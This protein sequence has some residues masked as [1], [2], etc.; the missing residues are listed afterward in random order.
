MTRRRS[1]SDRQLSLDLTRRGWGGA[2]KGAGRKRGHNVPHA[3]RP[4]HAL[5][6][7]VH[8][9]LRLAKHVWNLRSQRAFFH[10]EAALRRTNRRGLV[11]IVH[12]SVQ[13]NHLH[14]IVESRDRATLAS[15]IKGFEVRLSRGLNFMMRAKGRVLGDRYHRRDLRS[16]REVRNALVYVLN[17]R[18]HHDPSL[19][20]TPFIDSFSSGPFFDA[21]ASRPAR[22]TTACR[23]TGPP[24][25]D[26][27]Q[28]LLT[29]GW[30]RRG[31]LRPGAMR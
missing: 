6:H 31:L 3:R 13:H 17:N 12:F 30:K 29:T 18:V 16:P 5:T 14:L 8:V 7:P 23:G 2:R 10:V 9:T 20:S 4:A 27:K 21:W 22:V 15:G 28:W 24:T 19:Q 25:L 1:P 26:P 11:R